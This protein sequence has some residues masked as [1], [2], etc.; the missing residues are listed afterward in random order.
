MG[1]YD[2]LNEQQ[3]EAVLHTE[4]PLLIL[5][6]AG[7]GKT[8]V[9]THRIAYLIEEMG[10]NPWNILAITF[11]NK[12]AGEMRERV[13]NLV[14]IGSDSIWVSTF[15]SACV[16]ILRRYIGLLGYDT[17]FT[18]YDSDDQKTLMRDV[19]RMLNVD[20]KMFKE[21]MFLGAVSHAKEELITPQ[22]FRLEAGGDF[23]KLKVADVYEEYEKQ[24]RANNALDFDDLLVK[25]VQLFQT[26]ADVLDHYQERFRYIMV[27]EYQDTNTVQFELVRI[28]SSKYR[29]L[30]VVGDDDQSI[31]KFR[32][33]NI[34]NILNFEQFFEDA[35]VIKLEQN[36]R[37]TGNIL[38]AANAV[39]RHNAGRKDKTL[40][41]ANGDGGK[42]E[43]RQFDTA[44]DEAE[45]IVGDIAGSVKK[46]ERT[47]ND[48]AI[49]YR[50]NAQSRVFE[51]KFVTANIPYK[52][53][54]GVNFYARRE[55]KDLLSYLK[56]VDNGKDDLAVRRIINVPK[57]GIGLTSVNRVQEYAASR[58]ISFYEALQAADLI[59]GIGRGLAKLESF[60]ALIE[61]YKADAQEMSVSDLMKEIIEET[62]YIESLE[63][64]D[65]EEA[66]AR[67]ENIDELISKIV[68]YEEMCGDMDM[69]ATLGGFLEE[70]ALVADIDSLD[71][72]SD[73]VVLMTLHSAK[74]LEFPHVYL[75]GLEDGLF[76]SYMSITSDDLEDI[77]EERR[78]CY[79]GITRAEEELTLT[80][81]RRRMVRGETQYNRMSRFLKEIPVELVS[82]GETFAGETEDAQK[83]LQKELQKRNAYTQAKQAFQTKV[84][85][86]AKPAKQFGS[87]SG[88]SLDYEVGDR[89]RHVKFG[90]GT[91]TG[92]IEGGRD[93]EVTVDFDGPGTKKMFAAFAKLQKM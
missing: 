53:V 21:R 28:L 35:R 29:N 18:I 59:P 13:D 7:S 55:I 71:E 4:G 27:D 76:P 50:T 88:S 26:Q 49:L 56:T 46:E 42:L 9:L 74:G 5:A 75:A 65:A 63:N 81:A 58:E 36:Y 1:I 82:T 32:G 37:S 31:Y 48:H 66:E 3:R 45:Y 54:G 79:V 83:E 19:C 61:H 39:I 2:T 91:V 10:V 23:V 20:T 16:R 70:V 78:L 85:A 90:E 87:P 25:T 68:A 14:G 92:I 51:E 11:T 47:Y 41:T 8:R 24:L 44:Y 67:M 22:E 40:W 17:N 72:N 73:Y 80:C 43:F 69:P 6:G 60:T 64:E 12:A 33:A 15:H 52:I 93:Y 86:A 62:G 77:E 30:C 84:Y 38:N 57:R 89:V 34:R